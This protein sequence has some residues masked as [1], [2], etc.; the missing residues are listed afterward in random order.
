MHHDYDVGCHGNEG[1][2]SGTAGKW[3]S[4]SKEAFLFKYNK[5]MSSAGTWC[6]PGNFMNSYKFLLFLYKYYTN[7]ICYS[8]IYLVKPDACL[9]KVTNCGNHNAASCEYCPQEHGK[10]WC[11]GDCKWSNNQCVEKDSIGD[12]LLPINSVPMINFL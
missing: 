1:Y 12:N 11:N 7:L 3:S 4:C 2:L 6:L 10:G 5:V 8:F 9:K